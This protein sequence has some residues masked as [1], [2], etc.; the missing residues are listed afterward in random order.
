MRLRRV[1]A[2]GRL[3]PPMHVT[4]QNGNGHPSPADCVF[5]V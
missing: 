1:D 3:E 4:I 5:F 2:D